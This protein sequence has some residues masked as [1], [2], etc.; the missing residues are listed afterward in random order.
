M[1]ARH[2]LL[3]NGQHVSRS[4][5]FI[6]SRK[7]MMDRDSQVANDVQLAFLS[8]QQLLE[9]QLEEV[10]RIGQVGIWSYDPASGR[11]SW[12][13]ETCRSV[14]LDKLGF[15]GSIEIYLALAHP[16]ERG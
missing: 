5:F 3:G 11:L 1:R 15:D 2:V 13:D 14:G 9:R 10:Q 8:R 12:S 4:K 16:E 6:L 7:H